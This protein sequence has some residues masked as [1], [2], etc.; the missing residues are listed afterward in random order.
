VA[1]PF[2]GHREVKKRLRSP[3]VDVDEMLL[4]FGQTQQAARQSYLRAIRLGIDPDAP[5]EELTWRSLWGGK[6]LALRVDPE[7]VH[8][9]LLGR[10][11]G[12]ERPELEA[13][14]FI[15]RVCDLAG[16]DMDQLASR[17]RDR[18][19]ADARKLVA[20]LGVERWR[21][22]RTALAGV[23]GKNPDVVSFWAGEG[24]RRRQEDAGYAR[25]LDELDARLS[26]SLTRE[27]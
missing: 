20:T 15:Q 2:A 23:L 11:T 25:K 14:E 22:K 8:V 9:D 17:A 18:A 21:Q 4:C 13:G 5:A 24:A 3:V 10:S 26:T 12:L 19:T 16:F 6:D 1:Y 27:S 7:A